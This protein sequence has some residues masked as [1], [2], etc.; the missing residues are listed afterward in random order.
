MGLLLKIAALVIALSFALSATLC[1]L[2]NVRGQSE[3][4][5]LF[6][7]CLLGLSSLSALIWITH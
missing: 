1:V 7:L 5:A 4:N 3:A 6:W 2:G